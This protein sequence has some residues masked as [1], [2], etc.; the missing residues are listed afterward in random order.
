MTHL[1]SERNSIAVLQLDGFPIAAR[2]SPHVGVNVISLQ[3]GNSDGPG[4]VVASQASDEPGHL[5][6]CSLNLLAG[7]R[8]LH[9][10][11]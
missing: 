2:V 6:R 1:D 8:P 7:S 10:A 4:S 5:A 11:T 3:F 9:L